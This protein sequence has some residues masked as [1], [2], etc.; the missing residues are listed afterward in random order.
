[1]NR[2]TY[3]RDDRD[4]E[5]ILSDDDCRLDRLVATVQSLFDKGIR[6][7]RLDTPTVKMFF[8][9]ETEVEMKG[10]TG[11]FIRRTQVK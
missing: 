7:V 1:M 9:G 2:L 8:D 6:L 5:I 10:I 11:K 4:M 3:I